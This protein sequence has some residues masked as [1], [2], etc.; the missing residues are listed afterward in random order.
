MSRESTDK[1][2]VIENV[3]LNKVLNTKQHT[4]DLYPHSVI[5]VCGDIQL[6]MQMLI[7]KITSSVTSCNALV[8]TGASMR[9]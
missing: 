7:T 8:C 5:T 3:S 9:K 1:V 6:Y 2:A 4:P